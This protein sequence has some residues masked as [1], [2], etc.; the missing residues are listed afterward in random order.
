MYHWSNIAASGVEVGIQVM[1]AFHQRVLD[2]FGMPADCDLGIVVPIFKGK[3]DIRN[4]SCYGG[5]KLLE[6][7]MK[8][9]ERVLQRDFVE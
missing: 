1:A 5:V 6:H 4:S 9:V 3:C 8:V 2:G 7:E